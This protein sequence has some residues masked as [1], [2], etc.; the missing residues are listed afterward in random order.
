MVP[1]CSNGVGEL[2][3]GFLIPQTYRKVDNA[4]DMATTLVLKLGS[5][6]TKEQANIL[7][8]NPRISSDV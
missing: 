4:T 1:F 2:A 6:I 3:G 5:I 8:G 7:H